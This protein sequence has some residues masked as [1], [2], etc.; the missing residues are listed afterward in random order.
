M[1][2]KH[3]RGLYVLFFTEMW[4]RFGF[5]LMLA[6]FTLYL[7]EHSKLSEAEA[8]SIYGSYMFFVYL[9]PFFG[10]LLADRVFG[11]TRAILSGAA[12]LGAGYLV[13]S[14]QHPIAFY[15]ALCLLVLG[16]GL[17][18]PNISTLVGNLYPQGDSRRDSAFSI[19]YMGINLGALFGGPVGEFMR[20]TFGWP[21][22]FATAGVCMAFSLVTFALLRKHVTLG[23]NRSSVAAVFDMPLPAEYEDRPDPPA[24]ERQRIIALVVMCLIVMFFWM[25]FHQNGTSLTFWARDNTDRVLRVGSWSW[26]IPP[27][28]FQAFNSVFIIILTPVLVRVMSWLRARN[29]EPN[30]PAKI[31]IGM[32]LTGLSY[33]IL[34]VASWSGGD[35]GKVGMGWL[36]GC[37]FVIT[38][39]ELLL[40][41]MGLS[42]VTK[43]APRRMTAMLMGVW[44]IAT[45]VGNYLSGFI[46]RFWK[47][48]KHSEFFMLL[49]VTS[50]LA[51]CLLLWQYRRLKL[52]MPPQDPLED[53]KK[54]TSSESAVPELAGA[55]A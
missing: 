44:F 42:M 39:A 4:E 45:A 29:W 22:A 50:L 25:A 41:P 10:G 5:Y 23:D 52:A 1:A 34:V 53:D 40:S 7:T 21:L 14:I 38:I 9:T 36:I 31:G 27:G 6:L 20:M 54:Q 28:V 2:S 55:G 8:S 18:K 32:L 17:F 37:Y 26:E 3:P 48:W 15:A 46:G 16:N 47:P 13:F 24:V 30:T 19:F 43:L 12:L 35:H 51:A 11:Y 33:A 49:V